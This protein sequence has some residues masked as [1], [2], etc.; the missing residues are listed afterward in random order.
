M[1]VVILSETYSKKMGYSDGALSKALSR[2]G[3]EVHLVTTNLPPYYYLPDFQQTYGSF[4]DADVESPLFEDIDG[5]RVHYLPHKKLFGYVRMRGLFD[6]LQFLK[7]HIVQTFTA[8]SWIPLDAACFKPFLTYKLFTGSH[9]TASVFPLAKRKTHLWDKE[10]LKS[11]FT[12]AVCGRFVSF[13]SEKCYGA[14]IDCADIAVRFFGVQTSK[15]DICPL[16]VDTDLFS[17]INNEESR[18]S[19]IQTRKQLGFESTDIVCIYT[20]RFTNDKNPLLLAKAIECLVSLGLPFR[21]LFL[22]E[23]IQSK[24]IKNCFGCVI[25]PFV[26][27]SNLGN[28]FRSADIGVWPT[29]ESMSMLDAAACGLPIV[30][31]DTL[32]ARERIEGNGI[33][34]RL[35][36]VNDLVRVLKSL[37]NNEMRNRLGQSG[38]KRMASE[39]SWSSLAKRRL[40]DYE[41]SLGIERSY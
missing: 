35:N 17:P 16:G 5:Y 33:T 18:S 22:G 11:I 37:V 9:T 2:L 40:R 23:G 41:Y 24:A 32:I 30:V 28:Y 31:N 3:I 25:H 1:R 34:Y 21:G 15:I 8:I 36:D 14:T 20:G 27:F 10:N 38:A 26:P 13:F 12:R 6:K 7:P 39:F 29:Q 4:V 19:R